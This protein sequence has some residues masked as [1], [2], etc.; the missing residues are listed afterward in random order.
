MVFQLCTKPANETDYGIFF[1]NYMA[2]CAV[3][4]YPPYHKAKSLKKFKEEEEKKTKRRIILHEAS[5]GYVDIQ[6]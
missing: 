2:L 5:M 6:T 1:G 3:S 4:M